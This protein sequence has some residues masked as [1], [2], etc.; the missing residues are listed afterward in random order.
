MTTL[1]DRFKKIVDLKLEEFCN[2]Y[3]VTHSMFMTACSQIQTTKQMRCLDQLIACNNFLLFKRMM[4]QR[5]THL[6]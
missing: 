4:I 5:N 2:E 1:H 3:N 6:N